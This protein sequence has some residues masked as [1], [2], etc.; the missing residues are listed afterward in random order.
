MSLT[1][2]LNITKEFEEAL[3]RFYGPECTYRTGRFSSNGVAKDTLIIT[4]KDGSPRGVLFF[5]V[6]KDIPS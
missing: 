1:T 6:I 4:T 2:K 5:E 3:T